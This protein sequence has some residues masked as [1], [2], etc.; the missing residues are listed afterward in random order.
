MSPPRK[1]IA[2]VDDDTT[3]RRGVEKYLRSAGF[4]CESFE[5]A[6][7]F[8]AGAVA[9]GAACLLADVHLAGMSGLE[10]A[11]HPTV[12]ELNLPVVLMT[13][14]EDPL[15]EVAAREIS[16]A[17]LRKPFACQALLDAIVDTVGPPIGDEYHR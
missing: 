9:S 12:G 5:T 10:L 16:A 8:L 1:T 3:L 4:R 7:S 14:S 2:I 17:F 15:I 11:L 13:G 6:E